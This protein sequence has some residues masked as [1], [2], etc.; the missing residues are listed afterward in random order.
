E[1]EAVTQALIEMANAAGGKDN[2]TVVYVEGE[3]FASSQRRYPAHHRRESFDS[4]LGRR[5]AT[6]EVPET[7]T[8]PNRSNVVRDAVIAIAFLAAGFGFA[9]WDLWKRS[10][11]TTGSTAVSTTS[12]DQVVKPTESI[13][14]AIARAG[15]GTQIIVEPG[16]YRER[17]FLENGIRLVSRIPRGATIR[18]PTTASDTDLVAAV[19]ADRVSHAELTGFKI[20]GDAA[21][22]LGVGVGVTD[23]DVAVMDVEIVGATRAGIEFGEN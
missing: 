15:A 19:V 5:H 20:I 18:L 17:I 14:A 21:T 10:A 1:P 23:S 4:S 9:R 13:A 6:S 7:V 2:V 3:K 16:E 8:P 12:D 11:P 22:P